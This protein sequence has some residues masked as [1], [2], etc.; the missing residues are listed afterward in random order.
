[1][2]KRAIHSREL[3]PAKGPYS[4]AVEAGGFVFVSGMG[5]LDP[6]TGQVIE[7]SF[8]DMV[9]RVLDNIALVLAAAGLTMADVVKT[10]VFLADIGDF[11]EMNQVYAGYFGDVPP[12][13]TTI[14][15]ARLPLDIR[16]EIEAIARREG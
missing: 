10:T 6:A 12:A 11:A 9:R 13:R 1:M 7:G 4:P 15:A 8:A 14:Q 2:G 3:P 5:P 16:V